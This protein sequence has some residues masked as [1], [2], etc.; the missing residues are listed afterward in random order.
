[1]TPAV[2]AR[3]SDWMNLKTNLV[4]I[5]DGPV[6][7]AGRSGQ[8]DVGYL[9]AW[10]MRRGQVRLQAEGKE[11]H[12][13]AGEWLLPWPGH[14]QQLFSEDAEL[15][16]VSF[17]A[18]WPDG[19]PFFDHG[20]SAVFPQEF[21]SKLELQAMRLLRAAQPHLPSDP[22]NFMRSPISFEAF[23]QIKG[24]LLEWLLAYYEALSC[25]GISP[26]RLDIQDDRVF[27]SLRYLDQL[28][29]DARVR[30]SEL[31]SKAG[32]STSQ[33]V[34]VFREHA[35]PTPKQYFEQRRRDF[36]RR[37]LSGSEVPIKQIA[38]ELGFLRLS[39]FSAW[40]KN[41][42]GMSPRLFRQTVAKSG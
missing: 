35:G 33:F 21:G 15:L 10:L 31:A 40:F 32:L 7:M 26:T 24:A 42:A 30:E 13:A 6:S 37:M 38:L 11:V 2:L 36:V 5:Y 9:S 8:F 4:W 16:S 27:E 14:R 19:R 17:Y 41:F 18:Q 39:D 25:I 1:M 23:V 34:R 28:P 22:I 12:A 3:Q 29:L 20:L